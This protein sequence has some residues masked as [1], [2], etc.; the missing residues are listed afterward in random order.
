[1]FEKDLKSAQVQIRV[2]MEEKELIRLMAKRSPQGDVSTWLM[3]LIKQEYDR[4]IEFDQEV[5]NFRKED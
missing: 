1:M 2:T 5:K 3:H 4:V